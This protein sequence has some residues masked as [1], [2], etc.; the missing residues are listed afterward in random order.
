MSTILLAD[1]SLTI[2]KV[3]ELTFGET[4]HDVIAV[5]DGAELLR[6]LPEVRPD[7]VICDVIMPGLE[8]YEV[9]QQIKSDPA[10]LHIP[11][12]LL[13]GTFEPFDRDRA[14]AA[15]CSEIIT[16]PFEARKLV[17]TVERLLAAGV[18]AEPVELGT[19]PGAVTPPPPLE[20]EPA[21]AEFGTHL[22]EPEM[23]EA[24]EYTSSGFSEM[25]DAG[26]EAAAWSSE[27][28]EDGLE[29]EI[30]DDTADRMQSA[31]TDEPAPDDQPF[32]EPPPL[33]SDDVAGFASPDTQDAPFADDAT[34]DPRPVEMAEPT[35][36]GASDDPFDAMPLEPLEPTDVEFETPR[37]D[38]SFGD[39][40]P[41][42]EVESTEPADREW[43]EPAEDE[44]DEHG[45]DT[46]PSDAGFHVAHDEPVA[47][48]DDSGRE[49]YA[50]VSAPAEPPAAPAPT[51][52]SSGMP[53][54]SDEDVERIARRVAELAA[55]RIEQIAWDVIPDM[56]EIV[57]RE[58]VR[59]LEA[60]I[61]GVGPDPVQ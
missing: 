17:D 24:L 1:D 3:V 56:A 15:G 10:T 28:P 49:A 37:D 39:G 54:L 32:P 2:Q 33:D 31:D 27:P 5:P 8:G 18:E 20:P 46:S 42:A 61:E 23:D 4:E 38:A 43:R 51:A 45:A 53:V 21:A 44:V 9:C 36:A 57:V 30:G 40:F 7:V 19:E 6:R 13:T 26:D 41:L 16:K 14:L 59:E 52:T 60:E 48:T 25:Q 12:I 58:R 35:G 11:V 47:S 50:E 22:A 29:F 55:E 34:D